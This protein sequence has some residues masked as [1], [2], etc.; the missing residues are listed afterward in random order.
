MRAFWA[1]VSLVNGGSGGRDMMTSGFGEAESLA[2]W[3]GKSM[4]DHLS[5]DR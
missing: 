2:P 4:A 5:G 3:Q 1:A